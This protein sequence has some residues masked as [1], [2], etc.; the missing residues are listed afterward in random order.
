MGYQLQEVR[1]LDVDAETLLALQKSFPDLSWQ[2][3]ASLRDSA[4]R[5]FDQTFV[6]T[7]ILV[8]IAIGVA[9]IGVYIA[10][11]VLRLNQQASERLL[12][13][14]GI[15]SLERRGLDLARGLGVG[16]IAALAAL[17]LG[18][19]FGWI[20]CQVVNPRAFGWSVNLQLDMEALLVPVMWG[21]FAAV[22]ASMIRIGQKELAFDGTR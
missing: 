7:S 11:T 2:S 17:P 10:V 8:A 12:E 18:W 14:L 13:G 16:L 1:L 21:L 22:T 9:G 20:L 5:T 19:V 6:I 3:Q 15:S 4:L